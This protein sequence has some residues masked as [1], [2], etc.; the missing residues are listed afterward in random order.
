M[1]I[2]AVSVLSGTTIPSSFDS[3]SPA[4]AAD[5]NSHLLT[6]KLQSCLLL[7]SCVSLAFASK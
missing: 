5:A 1:L 7:G 4:S 6:I 2:C 3:S